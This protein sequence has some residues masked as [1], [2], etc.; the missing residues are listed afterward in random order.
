MN[1]DRN[2]ALIS[3]LT[4]LVF[5]VVSCSSIPF[6]GKKKEEKP[7][8]LSQGKTITVEGMETIK[9]VNPPKTESPPASKKPSPPTPSPKMEPD[10]R[11]ASIP[12][13]PSYGPALP[14]YPMGFRKKVVILD[15]E[16][17]TTYTE[18]KVEEATARRLS[19]KLEA[20]QRVILVDLHTVAETLGKEGLQMEN[21]RDPTAIKR[22]HA[23][24][25]VQALIFGTVTDLGLLSSKASETSDE[26]V[27]FATAK[28]EV[29]L[30]DA[31]TANPLR[32][33][34][35]RSPIFGTRETG[36]YHRSKAVMKAIDFSLDEILEGLLR[37]IDLLDWQTTIARIEGDMLYINAG[38]LSGLRIGDTLQVFG[39]GQEI[40]NPKT[41][42]SLGWTTGQL[43]GLIRITDLF[44]VDAAAGKVIQGEGFKPED[45]VKTALR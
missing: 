33:F 19:D 41:N 15:F 10:T 3:L 17:K 8:P 16:N 38:R 35:G 7:E 5:L 30:I 1:R 20:S 4:A 24:L 12:L 31:S 13:R 32:T 23:I 36:E 9:G 11:T 26:E 43:K 29:R 37:H 25:G 40:I 44:G 45:V 34:I 6:F 18:E 28:V 42:V 22:I 27:S 14:F 2:L 21:L 39:P